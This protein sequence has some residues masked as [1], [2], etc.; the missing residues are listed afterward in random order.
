MKIKY[1]SIFSLITIFELCSCGGSQIGGGGGSETNNKITVC[2]KGLHINGKAAPQAHVQLYKET[3]NPVTDK[4]P[5][6]LNCTADLSGEFTFKNVAQGSY[7]IYTR[8]DSAGIISMAAMI[9]SLVADV[10]IDTACTTNYSNPSI[11]HCVVKIDS[12]SKSAENSYSVYNGYLCIYGTPFY[13]Q[14]N[15]LKTTSTLISGVPP[16]IYSISCTIKKPDTLQTPVTSGN[17]PYSIENSPDIKVS[18]DDTDNIMD[19]SVT[20]IAK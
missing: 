14:E 16:G 10:N 2:V 11:I 17:S 18:D 12:S 13:S 19:V 5:D 4:L 15:V 7:N 3:F 1:L 8:Y 9:K 6:S 20:I